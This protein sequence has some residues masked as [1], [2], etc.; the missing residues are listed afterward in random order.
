MSLELTQDKPPSYGIAQQISP[1]ITRVLCNNPSPFTYTG[2]GTYLVGHRGGLA[3][4]DP[5]PTMPE[6]GEAIIKAAA[7]RPITHILITHCH[8][9]HSPLADWLANKTGATTYGFGPHGTG[10]KGPPSSGKTLEAGADFTFTPQKIL[11]D[12][13]ILKGADW[14]LRAIHTPGHTA[15][16]LCFLLEGENILFTGDHIMGWSTTVIGPPDGHMRDYIDSLQKVA[17]LGADIMLPTHGPAIERPAA[18]VRGTIGHRRMRETQILKH[19]EQGPA[20]INIM[21]KAMYKGID[22]KLH[23]AASWSV[24]VHILALI[25]DERVCT[26]GEPKIDSEYRLNPKHINP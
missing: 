16:H 13:E 4:I 7:S 22:K 25:E 12:G 2:T 11:K 5:G 1:L 15:N 3:V 18:F 9:D 24:F 20:T 8:S 14:T 19:L 6:H 26:A 23:A 21:V 10:R 17:D